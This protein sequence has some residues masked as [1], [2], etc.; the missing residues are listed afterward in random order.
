MKYLLDTNVVSETS[1][2]T[3]DLLVKRWLDTIPSSSLYISVLT[4]GE[5]RKGIE[6]LSTESDKKQHLISWLENEIPRWFG[7]NILPITL[8][9]ADKWGYIT[10]F[11]KDANDHAIDSLLAATALAHNM[12]MVTRNVKHFDVPG[13][14]V[15][16][17]WNDK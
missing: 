9:V 4:L 16:N 8:E 10:S 1:K 15:I 14:E 17:P 5:I 13:L 12:K 3:F 6:K 11:S 2:P 7:T